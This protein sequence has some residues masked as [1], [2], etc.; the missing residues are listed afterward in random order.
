MSF[1]DE[2]NL[3]NYS[4]KQTEEINQE[5]F[6][7]Y[8]Y[9]NDFNFDYNDDNLE[10]YYNYNFL[11]PNNNYSNI[12]PLYNYQNEYINKNEKNDNTYKTKNDTN[13]NLNNNQNEENNDIKI[14]EFGRYK[15]KKK[16]VKGKK[17]TN[18]GR[19]KKEKAMNCKTKG[20]KYAKDNIFRKIKT[21]FFNKFLISYINEK[22]K[23]V[24]K[25]QKYLVRKFNKALVT[26]VSIQ[27]NKI[28]DKKFTKSK[29]FR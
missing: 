26:D 29:N 28:K 5:Y 4:H 21:N 1:Y 19:K 15:S 16:K 8:K 11:K 18:Q 9:N 23:C 7:K 6:I 17:P 13:K 22:I 25:K 10:I 20:N 3:D 14:I 2:K 24:Y 27:F 12:Y